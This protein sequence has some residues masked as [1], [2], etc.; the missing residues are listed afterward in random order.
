TEQNIRRLISNR[1]DLFID[2]KKVALYIV[3]TKLPEHIGAIE[4]V[5]PEIE[6]QNFHIGFSKKRPHHKQL[7]QDFNQGLEIIRKNGTYDEILKLH[8]IAD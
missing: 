6:A 8:K 2:S 7:V 1:I 5:T 3:Q 4:V